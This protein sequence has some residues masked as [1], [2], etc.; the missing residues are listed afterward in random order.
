[1]WVRNQDDSGNQIL[2][3]TEDSKVGTEVL[4]RWDTT[5]AGIDIEAGFGR[6]VQAANVLRT[7][8]KLKRTDGTTV[9]V[10]V[11]TGTTVVASTTRP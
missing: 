11:D 6:G 9:Y 4:H 5:N 3:A 2:E 7:Y 1:M 8:I 10:S